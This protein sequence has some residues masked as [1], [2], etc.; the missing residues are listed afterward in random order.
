MI[1]SVI[2]GSAY[3]F[4]FALAVVSYITFRPIVVSNKTKN[5]FEVFLL[6]GKKLYTSSNKQDALNIYVVENNLLKNIT[7]QP[8]DAKIMFGAKNTNYMQMAEVGLMLKQVPDSI[9]LKN[10]GEL[11]PHNTELLNEL[12][13]F[14]VENNSKFKMLKGPLVIEKINATT[15][16]KKQTTA[17]PSTFVY[18]NVA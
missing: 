6:R 5:Y 15:W 17:R 13:P 4:F 8:G 7:Q 10:L 12:K 3:L 2:I 18:L 14:E 16:V 1:L 11:T 9:W